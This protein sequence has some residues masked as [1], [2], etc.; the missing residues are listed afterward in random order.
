MNLV[1]TISGLFI[2]LCSCIDPLDVHI[3]VYER[4]L[5]VD[6]SVY[7]GS[8]PHRV[9]LYYSSSFQAQRSEFKSPDPLRDAQ[10]NI[11][12][13]DNENFSLLEIAPGLYEIPE[14]VLHAS[15]GMSYQLFIRTSDHQEYQSS[16]QL[17]EAAGEIE[18]LYFEFAEDVLYF[19]ETRQLRDGF[20]IWM[21]AK[22]DPQSS[23]F[24]RW[25]YTGT[26]ESIS[27]PEQRTRV[28]ASASG[29]PLIIPDPLLCSGYEFNGT[30]LV[31]V[32]P[33]ECCTCWVDEDDGKVRLASR[34][35]NQNGF[36]NNI[37]LVIIPADRNRFYRKYSIAVEQLSLTEEAYEFWRLVESQ[38]K[39]TAS[40][41]QPNISIIKGNIH[42]ITK[43]S[44]NVIGFFNVSAIAK[45]RISIDR[46]VIPYCLEPRTEFL[47]CLQEPELFFNDCRLKYERSTI[48]RPI[49]W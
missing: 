37:R 1:N 42:N 20:I 3:P 41:F 28:E 2:V 49:F 14:N 8:G 7:E 23:G 22:A 5:V 27:Q 43:P 40:L 15:V 4:Q 19:P 46:L 12:S 24:L 39:G 35:F 36:F 6:G 33:C 10:V 9:R 21:D 17:M 47:D 45:K 11:H 38:Q 26:Y 31:Q 34:N 25:R 32:G 44:E 16:A 29:L 13:S 30:E 48:E 18:N